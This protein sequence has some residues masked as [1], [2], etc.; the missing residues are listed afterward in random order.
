MKILVIAATSMEVALAA[1]ELKGVAPI[2]FHITGVG[3][4]ATA[5][6]LT[7]LALQHQPTLVIQVGIAGAFDSSLPLGKVVAVSEE[8]LGDF[9]VE[10]NGAWKDLFA[11]GF[12]QR[13]V[14]PFTNARLVNSFLQDV[15]ILH[16]PEVAAITANEITTRPK[17]IA[18]L[19]ELYIPSIE[20]M[21]G[22][23]LHYVC[24]DIGIPYIQLRGIS[25]YIGERDKS[26][27]KIQEA[28]TNLNQTL[29]DFVDMIQSG[30][31]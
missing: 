4:L 18:Q 14:A 25:N 2:Q 9:G 20:S 24:N 10:E 11:M 26:K 23:A 5:V 27:W 15:N 1:E 12:V 31:E 6:S 30:V 28:I 29:L 19:Q 3:M 22:A 13:D 8:I 16:L 21:E 7:K 17:R